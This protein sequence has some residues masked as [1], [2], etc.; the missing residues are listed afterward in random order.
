M[1]LNAIG[2]VAG[3]MVFLAAA[4][5]A[6]PATATRPDPAAQAAAFPFL[7]HLGIYGY[8]REALLRLVKFPQ[9]PLEQAERLEQLRALENGIPIAVVR[10]D[11]AGQPTGAPVA[12]RGR[13]FSFDPRSL[14]L[15]PETGG[16]QVI[17]LMEALRAS[18]EKA[19][20]EKARAART[21]ARKPPKRARE[22]E[23]PQKKAVKRVAG[24]K[25]KVA[26]S[27]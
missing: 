12:L 17:D 2:C 16:A 21:E 10:V 8:R 14:D 18:L 25:A 1:R 19:P 3:V 15:R 7:K 24:A 26:A 13:D 9:S 20:R 22:A 11:A 4:H 6:A 5:G 27:R 23:A